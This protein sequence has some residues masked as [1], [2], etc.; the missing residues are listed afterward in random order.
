VLLGWCGSAL[1]AASIPSVAPAAAPSASPEK[2]AA[3]LTTPTE[4]F[5]GYL[6]LL[7]DNQVIGQTQLVRLVENLRRGE[8]VNPISEEEAR[9]S[10]SLQIHREGLEEYVQENNLDK[11]D[12]LRWVEENLKEKDRVRVKREETRQ[13]TKELHQQMIFNHVDPGTF[14]MGEGNTILTVT[15]SQPFEFM[16]TPVTQK[17]WAVIMGENPSGFAQGDYTITLVIEGKMVIMQ[18]D[19]PV[20]RVSWNDALRFID[21]LNE[22]SLTDDPRLYKLIPDHQRGD[23]YRLPWESEWEFVAK[24]RGHARKTYHFGDNESELKNYAWYGDNSNRTT[25]LVGKFKGLKIDGKVFYDMLGNVSEW[26]ED[27][28]DELP[29]GRNLTDPKGKTGLERPEG[30]FRIMRGGSWISSSSNLRSAYRDYTGPNY[31]HDS[32]GFR[33]VRVRK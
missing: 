19:H 23:Q 9:V 31:R 24:A 8:L 2:C 17:Q 26:V 28:Y 15:I 20:E 7:L 32:V 29:S 30:A 13:D 4:S 16:S 22:L 12:L 18:P 6:G 10:S 27:V 33:L 3:V 1:A 11:E 14:L 5:I 25:H 21:K